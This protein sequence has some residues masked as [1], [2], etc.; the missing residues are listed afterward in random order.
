MTDQ[1]NPLVTAILMDE[2][3]KYEGLRQGGILVSQVS[4][5][6]DWYAIDLRFRPFGQDFEIGS[7]PSVKTEMVNEES[8]REMITEGLRAIEERYEQQRAEQ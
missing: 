3:D 6:D 1:Y 2:F 4:E 5:R 8:L 7:F